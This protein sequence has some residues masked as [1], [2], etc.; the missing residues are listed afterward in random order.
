MP[1]ELVNPVVD[2]G[3]RKLCTRPYPGHK[4]GCPNFN[5]KKGCPPNTP[6]IYWELDLDDP[7]WAIWNV[8]D[9]AGHVARMKFVHPE[10]SDR[11]L[12]NCLYWQPSA[13]K[14]LRAEI[15]NFLRTEGKNLHVLTCPEATG[16]NV[17][18]TMKFLGIDLEWPPKTVAYQVVLAGTK[19]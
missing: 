7:I 3:M 8:F 6:T 15:A 11:Q 18:A 4:R 2:I 1:F 14:N 5:K 16:V 10:W 12:A 19:R 17:T 9:F 13:R